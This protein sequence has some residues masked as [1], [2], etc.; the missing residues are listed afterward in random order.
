MTMDGS[1]RFFIVIGTV[2]AVTIAGLGFAQ[3]DILNDP[4]RPDAE[5]AR[6]AGTK[7]LELYAFFGVEAGM[8]VADLMPAAGYNTYVLSPLVGSE[9]MVYSGPDRRG[10]LAERLAAN[11]L[12]NVEVFGGFGDIP[13]N[14]IDVM[15]TVRNMHH[16]VG[17]ANEART[18]AALMAALKPGGFM[19]VVDART[20]MDGYDSETHR[21]N[22]QF[23]IDA[24]EAAGFELVET[25]EMLGNPDDDISSFAEGGNRYDIDRLAVKFRKPGM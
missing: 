21:I 5:R 19:G 14:S 24:F 13:A 8:T 12:P 10:A 20:T 3:Q 9:G 16:V 23:V 7:P 22:Q 11:P 15:I 4:S 1:R 18:L 25:S 2:A 6:D 17:G